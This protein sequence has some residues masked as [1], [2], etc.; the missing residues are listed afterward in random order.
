MHFGCS[1]EATASTWW[2]ACCRSRRAGFAFSSSATMELGVSA[3]VISAR[4][5]GPSQ[6]P[7]AEAY[8]DH[9]NGCPDSHKRSFL[10]HQC[11]SVPARL[12]C[13]RLAVERKKMTEQ[14]QFDDA[15]GMAALGICELLLLA[16]TDLEIISEVAVRDV[17]TDVATAHREVCHR[18]ADT[19]EASSGDRNRSTDSR[20]QK[21]PASLVA[22]LHEKVAC[23]HFGPATNAESQ[24]SR[25]NDCATTFNCCRWRY[26]S[27]I[28]GAIA[29]RCQ[30]P[31]AIGVQTA[32]EPFG[33]TVE[34]HQLRSR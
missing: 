26:V 33:I 1:L 30:D 28:A 32:L 19:R 31:R 5:A 24:R 18:L 34:A 4:T 29:R 21:R 3:W 15:V 23:V 25:E 6:N 16:L 12:R 27:Q 7:D 14:A 17:L 22:H 11:G 20:R 8:H 10:G 13:D 9:R 2:R